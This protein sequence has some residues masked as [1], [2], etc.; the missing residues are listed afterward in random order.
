MTIRR[1]NI[2]SFVGLII[3]FLS[4]YG[5]ISYDVHLIW[6]CVLLIIF[7][8]ATILD[9]LLIKQ[10]NEIRIIPLVLIIV[11][12]LLMGFLTSTLVGSQRH[13]VHDGGPSL[14]GATWPFELDVIYPFCFSIF[15]LCLSYLRNRLIQLGIL[16]A[17]IITAI[18]GDYYSWA[19]DPKSAG[20]NYDSNHFP[21]ETK[22]IAPLLI[23]T[24]L[25]W[26]LGIAVKLILEK[27]SNRQQRQ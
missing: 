23:G 2:I 11:V 17:W 22:V 7:T 20:M 3:L 14:G 8:S 6:T 26:T 21:S 4:G 16:L 18:Y 24:V 10:S 25:F 19:K 13:D 27:T 5:R 12:G 15:I 9:F 1:I